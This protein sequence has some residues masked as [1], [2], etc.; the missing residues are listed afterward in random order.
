MD[1]IWHEFVANECEK[2]IY[3]IS[4]VITVCKKRLPAKLDDY[5]DGLR[6]SL[7]AALKQNPKTMNK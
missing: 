6:S 3:S 2:Y 7:L 1:L 5:V 4:I